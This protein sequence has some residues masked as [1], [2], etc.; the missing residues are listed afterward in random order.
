MAILSVSYDLR[1]HGRQDYRNLETSIKRFPCW[2][3]ALQSLWFIQTNAGS[4]EVYAYLRPNLGRTDS[5]L[6]VPVVV[7][8][9]WSQGLRQDVLDWLAAAYKVQQAA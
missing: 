3:H 4:K 6:V 9:Y 1:E 8:E 7:Y 2:C 5:L